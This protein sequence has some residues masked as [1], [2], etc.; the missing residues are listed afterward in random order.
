MGV[1]N[2][3]IKF[4]PSEFH[5]APENLSIRISKI[6]R[7]NERDD[8]SFFG[9]SALKEQ[10][11]ERSDK[12]LELYFALSGY[13]KPGDVQFQYKLEGLSD[14]WIP[15]DARN[16]LR[17]YQLPAGVFLL[18][19]RAITRNGNITT[20]EVVLSI[21]M[22]PVFYQTWWF[23]LALTI[24]TL[25]I[26]GVFFHYR[27]Q[28]LRSRLNMRR[29]IARDLH[30][31]FGATLS[32]I[33]MVTNAL[34]AK[35]GQPGTD[36]SR[37]LAEISSEAERLLS[38]MNDIVWSINPRNDELRYMFSRMRQFAVQ[39]LESRHVALDF[40]FDA[41]LYSLRIPMEV[42]RNLYLIFKEA[43]NNMAKYAGTERAFIG[44]ERRNSHLVFVIQDEGRGFSESE[45]NRGNGISN[46]KLRAAEIRSVLTIHSI[47]GQGTTITLHVPIK[48]I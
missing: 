11:L 10:V 18:R 17:L 16:I 31:D 14:T 3:V 41:Q 47:I 34:A 27:I 44:I 40:K 5:N 35:S 28:N 9:L 12:M 30:D 48:T 15:F 24:L 6:I 25:S 38:S 32:G 45:D 19:V 20:N 26:V 21:R 23:F 1:M 46:M 2:G 8:A 42:R 22:L 29:Q 33:S 4:K 13:T 43:V 37:R 39:V 36:V 7:Y